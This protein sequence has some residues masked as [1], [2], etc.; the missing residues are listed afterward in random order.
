MYILNYLDTFYH[1]TRFETLVTTTGNPIYDKAKSLSINLLKSVTI[2]PPLALGTVYL[3]K[4][5]NFKENVPSLKI[6]SF[7]FKT[8]AV[9]S[10]VIPFFKI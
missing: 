3:V 7:L 8:I 4:H 5:V 6:V 2:V 1:N 10:V 9:I